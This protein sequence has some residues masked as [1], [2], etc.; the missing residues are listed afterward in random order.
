MRTI[1]RVT[2]MTIVCIAVLAAMA[3][4][5]A[6]TE[7]ITLI[8]DPGTYIEETGEGAVK[9][10]QPSVWS[11][12]LIDLSTG[13]T[14]IW[15]SYLLTGDEALNGATKTFIETFDIPASA[16]NIAATI[17]IAADDS[18]RMYLNNE[19]EPFN[20]G[21]PGCSSPK[22]YTFTPQVGQNTLRIV[23][24]NAANTRPDPKWNPAGVIYRADITY[25]EVDLWIKD[26]APDTGTEPN[27]V[28]ANIWTSPDIWVRNQN[29]GSDNHVHQNPIYGKDNYVYVEVH[30]RGSWPSTAAEDRVVEVYRTTASTGQGWPAGWTLIGTAPLGSIAPGDSRIIELPWSDLPQKG[31]YCLLA[32]IVSDEDPITTTETNNPVYNT[33]QNNNIAWRNLNVLGKSCKANL[34]VRNVSNAETIDLRIEREASADTENILVVLDLESLF[35]GWQANGAQ[36]EDVEIVGGTRIQ[37]TSQNGAIRNI[38]MEPAAEASIS[39]ELIALDLSVNP[40]NYSMHVVQTDADGA[41]NGGVSYEANVCLQASFLTLG[42]LPAACVPSQQSL[43][44][45]EQITADQGIAP[46][47]FALT[48]GS[49]P[50]GLELSDDGVLS[51]TLTQSSVGSH[52]FIMTA[53]DAEGYRGNKEYTLDLYA[54]ELDFRGWQF[55]VNGATYQDDPNTLPDYVD[56]SGFDWSAGLGTLTVDFKPGAAGEY[57]ITSA[58]DYLFSSTSPEHFTLSED[59]VGTP[60]EEQLMGFEIAGEEITAQ[61]G[62]DFSLQAGEWVR[63]TFA[64]GDALF[65]ADG[66]LLPYSSFLYDDDSGEACDG[67]LLIA[68]AVQSVPEPSALALLASGLLI[69][70]WAVVRRRRRK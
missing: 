55:D 49:L 22:Q 14:W 44:Y 9:T 46:Y 10:Y 6:A 43:N 60:A 23:V 67:A 68:G 40:E 52:T 33:F 5:S 4:S 57:S 61:L 18:V 24:K 3:G 31:H 39:V 64:I 8:S 58:F 32:R 42:S 38:P 11:D 28:S 53:V 59:T 17:E 21:N 13:T 12:S 70:A 35:A 50:A 20:T 45:H 62:W 27:T 65:G 51:G 54:C 41:V 34:T 69:G 36:G 25:D 19:T 48:Q 47:T 37:L 16:K 30:N 66:S 56:D 7:T 2:L 26:P 29:D 1:N 15:S 63:L